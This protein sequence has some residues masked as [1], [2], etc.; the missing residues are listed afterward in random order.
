[1]AIL[2]LLVKMTCFSVEVGERVCRVFVFWN[3]VG[4]RSRID[5]AGR[6]AHRFRSIFVR[7]I[8]IAGAGG[9]HRQL[10]TADS[11]YRKDLLGSSSSLRMTPVLYVGI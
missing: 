3:I 7:V 11:K 8:M 2:V 5:C 1:V 10:V 4:F 9:A 6:N